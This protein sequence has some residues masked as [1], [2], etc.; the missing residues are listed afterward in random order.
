ME[1]IRHFPPKET[2][3][4]TDKGTAFFSWLCTTNQPPP[5]PP[6]PPPPPSLT[7]CCQVSSER[8]AA[9][10]EE[11]CEEL[12]DDIICSFAYNAISVCEQRGRSRGCAGRGAAATPLRNFFFFFFM[13][14]KKLS[15]VSS[16]GANLS[17]NALGVNTLTTLPT[18]VCQ[19]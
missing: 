14:S 6:L 7:R 3:A 2:V 5:P 18:V 13:G 16:D 19:D 17:P 10:C 12:P 9:G 1:W 15:R 11:T 4:V 8:P